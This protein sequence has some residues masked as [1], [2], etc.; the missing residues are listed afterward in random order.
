M[1]NRK[2]VQ[3]RKDMYIWKMRRKRK[4]PRED[5]VKLKVSTGTWKWKA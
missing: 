1:F 2:K 4:F 5:H 3:Y